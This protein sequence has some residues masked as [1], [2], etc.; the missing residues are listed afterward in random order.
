MDEFRL[1]EWIRRS[2]P[3]ELR[4]PGGIGDD[5]ALLSLSR[6]R[7]Q[8]VTQDV[9]VDGIDFHLDR[10][11]PG[12]VAHKALAVNLSDLAAMG[13]RPEG[14]TIALGLSR[15]VREAWVKAFYRGL[16]KT[17]RRFSIRL[18][19]GDFSASATFFVSITAF[20]S[21]G[22]PGP[23]YRKGAQ[24]GDRIFV[25]G[26]LGGSIEGKHLLFVPRVREA[27]WLVKHVRPTAMIDVSDG[28]L[29]DL[30][31]LLRSSGRG[32]LLERDRIPVSAEAHKRA[33]KNPDRALLQAL[34]D[35]EDFELLFTA[36]SK[37]SRT[38]ER[39]WRRY[40]PAVPLTGIGTVTRGKSVRWLR[41]GKPDAAF[42]PALKGYRHF[43]DRR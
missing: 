43:K 8:V 41:K 22:R 1:I 40:F 29:Q 5:A 16:W 20:G 32:A 10:A 24:S 18:L 26:Q 11:G 34:S 23:V 19:G 21:C 39:K 14:F 37:C 3:D 30:G 7:R 42:R 28:L 2:M 38:L 6:G 13:A 35:G 17:A 12:A 15:G 36:S 9:L 25:T 31:H 27:L 33:G 4:G